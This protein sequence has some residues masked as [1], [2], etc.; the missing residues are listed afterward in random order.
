MYNGFDIFLSYLKI[1][2]EFKKELNPSYTSMQHIQEFA[3][4]QNLPSNHQHFIFFEISIKR[5]IGSKKNVN[6]NCYRTGSQD[7]WIS[8]MHDKRKAEL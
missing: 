7:K 6:K 8:S 5:L 4:V 2:G 1:C 3:W